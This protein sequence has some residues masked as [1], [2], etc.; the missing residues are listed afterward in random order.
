MA[1]LGQADYRVNS[2]QDVI[3]GSNPNTPAAVNA[4]LDIWNTSG[5]APLTFTYQ[6]ETA[7]PG[8]LDVVY[9]LDRL[10]ASQQAAIRSVLDEYESIINVSSSG[11]RRGRS[12]HEFRGSAIS[13]HGG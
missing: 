4:Q 13:A 7:Q 8:D 6:F 3:Q 11:R 2:V 1:A 12:R 10:H 5:Q 9:R